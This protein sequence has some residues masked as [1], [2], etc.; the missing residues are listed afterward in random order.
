M[1]GMLFPNEDNNVSKIASPFS[2]RTVYDILLQFN[3]SGPWSSCI[4]L[5]PINLLPTHISCKL[6]KEVLGP[7]LSKLMISHA[8]GWLSC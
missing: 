5:P 2:S 8:Y 3:V 4:F 7:P 6:V 1:K